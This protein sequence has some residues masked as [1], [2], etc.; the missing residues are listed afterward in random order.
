[1]KKSVEFIFVILF[2]LSYLVS[3]VLLFWGWVRWLKQ[4][5]L[6][7]ITSL[8]SLS[9]FVLASA[10]ALLALLSIPY[11]QVHRFGYYDPSLM[12]IFRWGVF[13]SFTGLCLG[14]GGAWRT[15]SLRW[16]SPLA[17]LGTLAFWLFSAAGE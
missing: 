17:A 5:K 8:L 11:A 14:I 7:T 3:P 12:R 1:M 16:F 15:S 6:R 4:S 13:L 9:G 2:A 10:S